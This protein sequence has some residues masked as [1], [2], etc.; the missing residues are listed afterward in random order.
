MKLSLVHL[1]VCGINK[2]DRVRVPLKYIKT[3]KRLSEPSHSF[4]VHLQGESLDF[5][6]DNDKTRDF[7][8]KVLRYYADVIKSVQSIERSSLQIRA[9]K[10]SD[11]ARL[12]RI[13]DFSI[14]TFKEDSELFEFT[15]ETLISLQRSGD[16]V[17]ANSTLLSQTQ[18]PE[19][20]LV[21]MF[22]F[23]NDYF[24]VLEVKK[25]QPTVINQLPVKYLEFLTDSLD[26]MVV[27]NAYLTLRKYNR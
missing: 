2:S 18:D 22:D 20:F 9:K 17:L 23:M 19:D 10:H 12:Q 6:C 3:V 27:K 8:V 13:L 5:K 21:R 25:L 7:W 4:S 15:K 11:F 26:Q 24:R 16:S 1:E 14:G